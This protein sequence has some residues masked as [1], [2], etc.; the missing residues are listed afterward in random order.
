MMA[1]EVA[2]ILDFLIFCLGVPWPPPKKRRKKKRKKNHPRDFIFL[3][4]SID[5]VHHLVILNV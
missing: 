2:T 3:F 4:S 5:Y 1:R